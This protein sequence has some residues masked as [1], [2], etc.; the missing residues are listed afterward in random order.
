LGGVRASVYIATSLVFAI[1]GVLI[2]TRGQSIGKVLA[3][4]RIVDQEGRR[5]GFV[6]GFVVRTVPFTMLQLLPP[7]VIDL[8]GSAGTAETLRFVAGL[9]ALWDVALI[10]GTHRQCVHDRIAGTYVAVA[11]SEQGGRGARA[12]RPRPRKKRVTP[13]A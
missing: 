13:P 2:A 6:R 5:A 12:D 10:F 1:N 4:T 7:M 8:G 11:G 9:V 3:R